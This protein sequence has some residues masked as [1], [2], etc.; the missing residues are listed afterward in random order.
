MRSFSTRTLKRYIKIR[1]AFTLV[2]LLAALALAVFVAAM[3][4][5][6][7]LQAATARQSVNDRIAKIERREVVFQRLASDLEHLLD[8]AGS[9]A[10]PLKLFGSP[11]QVL[12]L[13]CLAE[14]EEGDA[15]HVPMRPATVRY[16]LVDSPAGNGTKD[17]VRE[18]SDLTLTRPTTSRETL[19]VAVGLEAA[20][21]DKV[22]VSVGEV[23]VGVFAVEVFDGVRWSASFP[24]SRRKQSTAEAVR[25]TFQQLGD[26]KATTRTYWIGEDLDG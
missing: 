26:K 25:V 1:R 21:K 22:G 16:R 14:F 4:G 11:A 24:S 19:A 9:G 15:L 13:R 23:A 18:V 7:A 2:E 8:D 12:E 20:V 3:T 10:P 5:E 17:L 6:I